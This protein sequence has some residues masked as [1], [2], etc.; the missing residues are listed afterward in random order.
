[1]DWERRCAYLPAM[2]FVLL[3]GK[4]EGLSFNYSI[5]SPM[6]YSPCKIRCKPLPAMGSKRHPA[7]KA[8]R[9]PGNKKNGRQEGRVGHT[10]EFGGRTGSHRTAQSQV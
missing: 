1:M 5:T 9:L 2:R 3:T 4:G 7:P 10:L 8:R 6:N